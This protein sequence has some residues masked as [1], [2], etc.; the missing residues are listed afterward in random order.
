MTESLSEIDPRNAEIDEFHETF[1]KN[2]A[3]RRNAA[4]GADVAPTPPCGGTVK[5]P[6]RRKVR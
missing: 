1:D 3:V 2:G 5:R 6:F 4:A